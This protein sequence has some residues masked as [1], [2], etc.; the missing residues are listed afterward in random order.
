MIDL[1]DTYR[2]TVNVKDPAGV[3]V[4][5]ATT[6]VTVTLPDGTTATPT[7]SNAS[8]G[9]YRADYTTTQA[10]RHL[11]RWVTTA[12]ASPEVGTDTFDVQEAAPPLILS[13]DEAK[14]QLKI[15]NTTHDEEL[16]AYIE[17]VTRVVER[18]DG[19]IHGVGAVVRRTVVWTFRGGFSCV[20]LP[21][22]PVLSLASAALVTDGSAISTANWEV[23]QAGVLYDK[24]KAALPSE[25]WR[26][27]WV[28]GRAVV[29]ANIRTAAKVILQHAWETTR[30]QSAL[31][32]TQGGRRPQGDAATGMGFLIP[33]RAQ[34]L[35]A[36]DAD[37]AGFA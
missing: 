33:Y 18:G 35:L 24:T 26:L 36:P 14:T 32:A 12:P 15:T 31:A 2:L 5:D 9:V 30:P 17:G 10:G 7:V 16:R 20:P 37:L 4:N 13:L 1:G 3:L 28:A 29:T 8:T 11:V 23:D 27:T 34:A 25:A 22:T 21:V 6:A 19:K